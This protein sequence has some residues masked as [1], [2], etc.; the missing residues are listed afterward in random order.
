MERALAGLFD[1]REIKAGKEAERF[2]EIATELM[3]GYC[4]KKG[5]DL[6]EF[7]ELEFYLY[8]PFHRDII[9][10]PRNAEAGDWLFHNS[11]V[12]LCFGSVPNGSDAGRAEAPAGDCFGGILIRGVRPVGKDGGGG[13][14]PPVFGP[15][16]CCD[17]L[18]DRFSAI[19]PDPERYPHLVPRKR[20]GG[21][22]VGCCERYFNFLDEDRKFESLRKKYIGREP[23]VRADF[24][25]FL[26][27]RYRFYDKS[28]EEQIRHVKAF[29]A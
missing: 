4:I 7:C 21:V 25:K 19:V 22:V 20:D 12:D 18:F 2:L 17:M 9:T 24:D 16:K 28:V 23:I 27:A 8:A 29:P 3:A 11:G 5:G 15:L 1:I 14:E 26:T 6:Y 13:K 10:Y